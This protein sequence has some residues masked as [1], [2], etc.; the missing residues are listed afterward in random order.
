MVYSKDYFMS[1]FLRKLSKYIKIVTT[2]K[3]NLT[4]VAWDFMR[5]LCVVRRTICSTLHFLKVLTQS[6]HHPNTHTAAT[7]PASNI[8]VNLSLCDDLLLCAFIRL[9]LCRRCVLLEISSLNYYLTLKCPKQNERQC[10][11][12][13][14][15][16][17]SQF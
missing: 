7:C 1:F 16:N 4:S 5:L 3:T 11:R 13:H 10:V 12:L 14:R 8:V 17:L 9:Y 2:I 6:Y 15:L